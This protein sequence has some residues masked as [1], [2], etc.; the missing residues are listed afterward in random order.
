M[1]TKSTKVFNYISQRKLDLY[2][3]ILLDSFASQMMKK[4]SKL[5][6]HKK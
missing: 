5:K 2:M 6:K 3:D 1:K 4:K